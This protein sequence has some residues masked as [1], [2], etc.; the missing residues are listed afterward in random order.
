[1]RRSI[2]AIV[3]ITA[4]MTC[5]HAVACSY[6]EPPTFR[7]S[8]AGASSVFIFRLDNAQYRK[9]SHGGRAYSA[10][11]EGDIA[12]VQN[13]Y[14]DPTE[15]KTIKF[16]TYWCGGVNLVVGHHYLIATDAAG[17]TIQLVDADGSI[18]DVEGFY[19]PT[20]KKRNLRSHLI[21]PVIQAI[22]G[23]KPLPEGFPDSFIAGRTVLQPPPPPPGS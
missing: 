20:Q 10:W 18:F 4:A 11:V 12:L 7:E 13:L 16:S 15:Y 5:G 23:V 2:L 22:Y 6:S 14:G 19:N 8:L 9:E 21:L 3:A 1:M 17:D